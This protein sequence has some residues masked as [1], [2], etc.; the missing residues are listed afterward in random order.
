MVFTP[1]AS[2]GKSRGTWTKDRSTPY[3]EE[4]E[5]AAGDKQA[6]A[7]QDMDK[8]EAAVFL[9]GEGKEAGPPAM[10]TPV[11]ER[12]KAI[13]I[14]DPSTTSETNVGDDGVPFSEA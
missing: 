12:S 11:P 10:A 4:E 14:V 2:E 5:E 6:Y 7:T 3:V 9:A 13:P 8:W 1:S